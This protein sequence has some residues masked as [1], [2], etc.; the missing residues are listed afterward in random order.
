LFRKQPLKKAKFLAVS[1][2][3]RNFAEV[4]SG[5]TAKE[6]MKE[7]QRCLRCYRLMVWE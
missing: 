4:E 1:D 3:V 7:A 5:F 2:R 6:A